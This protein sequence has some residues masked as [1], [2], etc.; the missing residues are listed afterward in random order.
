MQ[1]SKNFYGFCLYSSAFDT[2]TNQKQLL[3]Y[4]NFKSHP[5][6]TST[7]STVF[8]FGSTISKSNEITALQ[9]PLRN[10][11]VLCF[12]ADIINSNIPLLLGFNFTRKHN[13]MTFAKGA[14]TSK[15]FSWSLP[16]LYHN[17]H[18]FLTLQ[19]SVYFTRHELASLHLQFFHPKA[20][21]L[22]NLLQQ[23]DSAK[24]AN[25]VRQ[26][27]SEFFSA[28]ANFRENSTRP[29]RFCVFIPPDEIVFNHK[30]ATDLLWLENAPFLHVI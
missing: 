17:G 29:Y 25:N 15:D 13:L 9:L 21:K 8:R 28:C 24:A 22:F 10:N 18:V 20:D 7:S 4:N 16:I 30:A 1:H 23:L 11:Q 2:A 19:S 14:V 6:K 3:A 27:L 5:A 12:Q 26:I